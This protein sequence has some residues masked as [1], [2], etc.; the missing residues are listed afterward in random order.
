MEL[1][2]FQIEAE[3][4]QGG[5]AVVYAARRGAER[6]ALKVQREVEPDLPTLRFLDEAHK[7]ARIHHPAIV[8]VV[9]SGQL[10]DGRAFVAMP[11]LDGETLAVR[12]ARGPMDVAEALRIFG[13]VASGVRAL[14]EAG[15]VHR[16]IKAENVMLI[17][18]PPSPVLLDLGIAKDLHAESSTT[19]QKGV[20]RGTPAT[21]APERFFGKPATVASDVYELG[22]LL[23]QML[24]GRLPWTDG[25]D[26]EARLAVKSLR[27]WSETIPQ[28][29]DE[30]V[31]QALAT[32]PA[33]RP[34]SIKAFCD[35]VLARS[36]PLVIRS[37]AALDAN[38][39]PQGT[40]ARPREEERS[41]RNRQVVTTGLA[42]LIGAAVT[43]VA[44][45]VVREDR[46]HGNGVDV[47]HAPPFPPVST[48]PSEVPSET[49]AAASEGAAAASSQ[50]V[51][52]AAN[53]ASSQAPPRSSPVV[54]A[55]STS[56]PVPSAAEASPSVIPSAG[57]S[58]AAPS[59]H[60]LP[61]VAAAG[62]FAAVPACH[63]YAYETCGDPSKKAF[64]REFCWGQVKTF[65]EQK[66]PADRRAYCERELA[67]HRKRTADDAKADAMIDTELPACKAWV[68]K[69]CSA[70]AKAREATRTFC[71][72]N[73]P[74]ARSLAL[75]RTRK[76]AEEVC[77]RRL[78]RFQDEVD[79][80]LIQMTEREQR[81][82]R[83]YVRLP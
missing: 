21:M 48:M 50:G 68:A 35:Q 9:D 3:I 29:I 33:R 7:L 49:K 45:H 13:A 40:S 58:D 23:H 64:Q 70:E 2:A 61:T 53:T 65:V 38:L 55:T 78:D 22:V 30:A 54:A 74:A 25:S 31:L 60:V 42:L 11:L 62:V 24:T 80:A 81:N 5:S 37:T 15:L 44:S 59:A 34:V 67:N 17:G 14:H 72:I 12:I 83:P 75:K 66:K 28:A 71:P 52:V 82:S 73:Q 26:T 4:G 18:D 51:V 57:S 39:T 47:G 8:A 36:E 63:T 56:A 19:T 6:L 76:E 77:Q 32:S 10:P 69:S 16:D 43:G 46:S 41:S 79:K 1:G 27:T 20:V